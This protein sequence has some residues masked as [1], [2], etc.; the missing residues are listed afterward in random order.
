MAT[1]LWT[2]LERNRTMFSLYGLTVVLDLNV[3]CT[4]TSST[5]LWVGGCVFHRV[6]AGSAT[7]NLCDR[8]DL[9]SFCATHLFVWMKT[10]YSADFFAL[11]LTAILLHF[12]WDLWFYLMTKKKKKILLFLLAQSHPWNAA[13]ALD[14]SIDHLYGAYWNLTSAFNLPWGAMGGWSSRSRTQIR[15]R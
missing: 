7:S 8:W 10:C 11:I 2:S 3:L 12:Q 1:V 9:E 4:L 5:L 15:S 14:K 13:S 6:P